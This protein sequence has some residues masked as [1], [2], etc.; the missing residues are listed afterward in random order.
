MP[1][2]LPLG[3]Q[4]PDFSLA[5]VDGRVY[6]LEDWSASL[7]VIF[8]TCNHCPYVVGSEEMTREL[9]MRWADRGVQFVA[10]SSNAPSTYPEDRFAEM[11]RRDDERPFPWPY[12]YD[13]DQSVAL[14]YG[15]LRTPHFYIFDQQRTLRYC[16][17]QFRTPRH[18]EKSDRD[19]VEEALR[20]LVAKRA[21]QTPLTNP[22]G[23]NVKWE[24][25]D[26]HWMPPEACDLVLESP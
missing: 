17:H 7:L 16:G 20:D 26:A 3:S 4:A 22:V 12:L 11:V 24:G 10:I 25:K 13:A 19:Q 1:F 5:G 6:Q 23:C 18:P 2:T 21:V 8:F 15:A 14:A 9:A